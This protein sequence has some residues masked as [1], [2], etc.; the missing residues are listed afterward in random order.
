M[1]RHARV[2]VRLEVAFAMIG[3]TLFALSLAFPRWIEA[4]TGLEPDSGSG[5][6]ELSVASA[7]LMMAI[8]CSTLAWRTQ[9]R[10]TTSQAGLATRTVPDSAW[11]GGPTGS[12]RS[13]P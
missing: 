6:A 5:H 13:S 1:N 11:A 3:A 4:L 7:F 12:P 10:A 8:C 9:R 2:A